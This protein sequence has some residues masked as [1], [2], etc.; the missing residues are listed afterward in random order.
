M[1]KWLADAS[2]SNWLRVVGVGTIVLIASYLLIQQS[3]RLA[4]DD[5]PLAT[6]QTTVHRLESGAKPN[7]AVPQTLTDLKSDST[8]FVAI[9][10][11]S[12][13]ILASSIKLDGSAPLP[14]DET[15][16]VAKS[17]GINTF[18]WK[19]EADVRLATQVL[20]Y[21][22]GFVVAG[23]SLAQAEKRI[24]TYG[25]IVLAAWL[26]IVLWATFIPLPIRNKN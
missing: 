8:V 12:Y 2:S 13:K 11:Q 14:P 21:S 25:W 9:T 15:L 24:E 20:P 10:D 5:L 1:K 17:K 26:G 19:P 22:G 16:A 4:A 18:T 7:E 6:A 23:Q 3:T